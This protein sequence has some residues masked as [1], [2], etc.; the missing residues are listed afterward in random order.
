MTELP[1]PTTYDVRWSV[2]CSHDGNLGR[3]VVQLVMIPLVHTRPM[4]SE[5]RSSDPLPEGIGADEVLAIAKDMC[6][7]F[8]ADK[9]RLRQESMAAYEE[10]DR[11]R[12]LLGL[13]GRP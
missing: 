9:Q 10:A 6:D 12:G 5:A 4:F 3:W 7:T 13:S 8:D 11:L 2:G 1:Q